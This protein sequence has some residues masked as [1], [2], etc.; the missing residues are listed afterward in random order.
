[1]SESGPSVPTCA[2]SKS[3]LS[4]LLGQLPKLVVE[5]EASISDLTSRIKKTKQAAGQT[6]D[7]A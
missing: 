6:A 3:E 1:M 5:T 7:L 2:D 4:D